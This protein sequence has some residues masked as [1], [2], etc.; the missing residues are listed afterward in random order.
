MWRIA[1]HGTGR[2]RQIL[3]KGIKD[4]SAIERATVARD[5]NRQPRLAEVVQ[6]YTRMFTNNKHA[7]DVAELLIGKKEKRLSTDTLKETLKGFVSNPRIT[8]KMQRTGNNA[9]LSFVQGDD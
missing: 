1:P 5:P 4:A 3:A 9:P 6:I 8:K 2:R 7:D